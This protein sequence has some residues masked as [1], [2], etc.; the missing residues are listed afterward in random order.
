MSHRILTPT[1]GGGYQSSDFTDEE[2][3]AQRGYV[4][5][6]RSHSGTVG[7]PGLASG[8]ESLQ[9]STQP[10]VGLEEG[11]RTPARPRSLSDRG[12]Q[13]LDLTVWPW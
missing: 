6:L 1:Q 2:T 8:L 9:R 11:A 12:T 3:E 13:A 7:L 10:D 5:Y 4:T